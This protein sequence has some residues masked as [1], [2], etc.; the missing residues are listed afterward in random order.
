MDDGSPR[1]TRDYDEE[2]FPTASRLLAP[3]VRAKVLAFYRFV[4]TADDIADHPR[5]GAAQKI[6]E[7]VAMERALDDAAT[8]L[9]Q[10]RRMH[11]LGV[12][13]EEARRMLS[14]FRQDAEK[15][16]YADWAELEDYC[17][18]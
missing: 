7:V 15:R 9:R 3:A 17:T 18:R 4:R 2:N 8:T 16:R 10:A 14:A 12:G 5:L 13:V 6:A 1:P 11:E